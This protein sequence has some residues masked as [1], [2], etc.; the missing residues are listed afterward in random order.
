M[1]PYEL[2]KRQTVRRSAI[3]FRRITLDT[4]K[5]KC[6]AVSVT[7]ETKQLKLG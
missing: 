6:L 5:D 4:T 2:Y 3:T 7:S 1:G